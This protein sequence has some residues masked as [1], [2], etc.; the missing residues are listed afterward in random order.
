MDLTGR[1]PEPHSERPATIILHLNNFNIF[2]G[3]RV[4]DD[5]VDGVRRRLWI[6]ATNMSI[7]LLICPVELSGSYINSHIVAK[8]EELVKEIINL[9]YEICVSYF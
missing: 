4:I 6:A 1:K 2:W 7:V 3:K 8:Q 9:V 5:H